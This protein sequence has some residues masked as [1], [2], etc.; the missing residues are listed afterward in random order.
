MTTRNSLSATLL[1]ACMSCVGI[2]PAHAAMQ[3]VIGSAFDITYDD[4]LTGLFGALS[5]TGSTIIFSPTTFKAKS[6]NGAEFV[7]ANQTFQFRVTPHTGIDFSS[8]SVS[9][10]GDYELQGAHSFVN[11]GGQ[12]RA[13]DV[14]NSFVQLTNN[15]TP[16]RHSPLLTVQTT[17]GLQPLHST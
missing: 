3:T 14:A 15:I 17:T 10:A 11:V 7:T 2:A 5:L 13:F 1:A 12:I 9:E 16:P 6:L 4:A 8:I